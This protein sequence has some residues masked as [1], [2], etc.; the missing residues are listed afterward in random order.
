MRYYVMTRVKCERLELHVIDMSPYDGYR[1]TADGSLVQTV[2][3]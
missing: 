1:V 3:V 2:T